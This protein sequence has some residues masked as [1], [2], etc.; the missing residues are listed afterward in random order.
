L[1]MSEIEL[2]I[3]AM[4][5]VL[6]VRAETRCEPDGGCSIASLLRAV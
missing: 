2:G 5:V 3:R 1:R 4:V 6:H